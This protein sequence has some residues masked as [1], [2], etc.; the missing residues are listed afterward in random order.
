MHP[1]FLLAESFARRSQ[2][3]DLLR[4][5]LGRGGG[6]A[7]SIADSI[8]PLIQPR[9]SCLFESTARVLLACEGDTQTTSLS[10]GDAC[11]AVSVALSL[12]LSLSLPPSPL[13]PLPLLLSSRSDFRSLFIRSTQLSR[14][15]DRLLSTTLRRQIPI[16]ATRA[17]ERNID[18][19][20]AFDSMF[21]H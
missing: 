14:R 18:F 3:D 21:D 2:L 6:D 11:F 10:S 13:S 20:V 5:D 16:L 4:F 15:C 8:S 12:S 1:H 17:S 9:P 19:F 7:G